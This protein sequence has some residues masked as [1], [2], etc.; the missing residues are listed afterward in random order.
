LGGTTVFQGDTLESLL[1]RAHQAMSVSINAGG[2]RVSI[3]EV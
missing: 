2:N 1:Q 3:L